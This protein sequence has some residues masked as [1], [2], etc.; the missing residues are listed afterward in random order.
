MAP[1]TPMA[2]QM[3]LVKLIVLWNKI[4]R[5]ESERRHEV[6]VWGWVI[7]SWVEHET[8]QWAVCEV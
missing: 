8:S 5:Q 6:A 3:S 4:N 7:G 2:I 1:P